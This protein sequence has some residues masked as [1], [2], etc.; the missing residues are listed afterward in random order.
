MFYSFLIKTKIKNNMAS[1]YFQTWRQLNPAEIVLAEFGQTEQKILDSKKVIFE[2]LITFLFFVLFAY[3]LRLI[4]QKAN[5]RQEQNQVFEFSEQVKTEESQKFYYQ[6][7][8]GYVAQNL[9]EIEKYSFEEP[10]E[11]KNLAVY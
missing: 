5:L 7:Q 6:F 2:I 11:D 4:D 3:G 9:I 1:Q 10:F 8:Q